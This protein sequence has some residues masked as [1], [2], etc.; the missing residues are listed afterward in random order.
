[1]AERSNRRPKLSL[2]QAPSRFLIDKLREVS[3]PAVGKPTE[4]SIKPEKLRKAL[5]TQME[6]GV[7][8]LE[9]I[10]EIK[11]IYNETGWDGGFEF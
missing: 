9:Q 4:Y 8:S 7:L 1:M 10:D 6:A 2:D 5:A 3:Q 11:R